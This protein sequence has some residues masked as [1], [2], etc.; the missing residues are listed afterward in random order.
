MKVYSISDEEWLRFLEGCERATFFHTPYWYRVWKAYAGYEYEARVYEFQDGKQVL[1]PMAWWRIKKGLLKRMVSSPAGTYG[2]WIARQPVK[3]E[4][5]DAILKSLKKEFSRIDIRLS[6]LDGT[7]ELL[8]SFINK[9]EDFTQVIDLRGKSID[10][11]IS[12]WTVNHKRSLKKAEGNEMVIRLASCEEDWENYFEVYQ[13]SI[14]RWGKRVSSD[15]S[16]LLFQLLQDVPEECCELWI[17]LSKGS[18]ISGCIVFYFNHHSVYWHGASLS[19]FFHLRPVHF[20]KK[21]IIEKAVIKKIWWYDFNPSGGHDGVVRFKKGFG[22]E[23]YSSTV[24]LY[25]D[26]LVKGINKISSIKQC[27]GF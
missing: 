19:E 5:V 12:N 15:Y 8:C 23:V 20:L 10:A 18:M 3:K 14:R 16:Y 4:E 6:W 25:T 1:L 2:G 24:I 21:N 27:L 13:D 11:I 26:Y 9:V 22:S 7:E 17:C